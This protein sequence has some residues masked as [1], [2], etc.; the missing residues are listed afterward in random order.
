MICSRYIDEGVVGSG[1]GLFLLWALAENSA[2][3]L[4]RGQ[5]NVCTLYGVLSSPLWLKFVPG[6]FLS[7]V[8][9][10]KVWG[11]GYGLTE[12]RIFHR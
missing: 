2:T 10:S 8:D 7:V 1:I 11:I 12:Y 3:K 9:N 4:K 6:N 5:L